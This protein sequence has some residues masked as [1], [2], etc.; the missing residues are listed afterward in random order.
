MLLKNKKTEGLINALSELQDANYKLS[1]QKLAEI[2]ERLV[3]GRE[4]FEQ[5]LEQ[6]I[7]A[8][9]QISSLDLTLHHYT[10]SLDQISKSVADATKAIHA[11]SADTSGVAGAVSGQHEELTNTIITASEESSSVYKKIEEGQEELTYIKSL[12]DS[13]IAASEEMKRDMDQL[14]QIINDMN[15]VIEGINSIS[16]QTNMLSLNAS[17]EAARAGEAGRGFAVVADEIRKLADETQTL[18]GTMG[19]FVEDVKKA[20]RKSV[21]SVAGTIDALETMTNKISHVWAL[22]EENQKH[23]AKIT[24]NISSLASV[25]EEISSSMIELENQAT[26]IQEECKILSEDTEK[27]R[28]I[29]IC[30]RDS[31]EPVAQIE[32]TLDDN[33]KMMGKMSQDAFYSLEKKEFSKYLDRAINAHKIWLVNLKNIVSSRTIMPLQLDDAKCGFGHFYYSITPKYPEI[34]DLWNNLGAK[35]KKFHH[36]GEEVIKALFAEDYSGAERICSEA[37]EFSK[38]L[39]HDLEEMKSRIS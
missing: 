12:S 5:I 34:I 36:Y 9:M 20:S 39:L 30:I 16:S 22:N 14:D 27:L 35:H 29:G 33:A 4:Q 21:D 17:I 11:S 24:D 13:T 2:Y 6:N 10:E 19:N 37:E 28:E 25:S 23:V 31:V 38:E 15:A 26:E 18:T 7:S 3:S 32:K 8:V 1:S